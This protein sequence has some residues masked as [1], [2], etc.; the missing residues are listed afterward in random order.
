MCVLVYVCVYVCACLYVYRL[1]WFFPYLINGSGNCSLLKYWSACHPATNA[2]FVPWRSGGRRGARVEQAIRRHDAGHTCHGRHLYVI[3]RNS[4]L[5]GSFPCHLLHY[6]MRKQREMHMLKGSNYV[7]KRTR[8]IFLEKSEYV[9][10]MRRGACCPKISLEVWHSALLL[11][12][13]KIF[14]CACKPSDTSMF[15]F[16]YEPPSIGTKRCFAQR[17]RR[18]WQFTHKSN[19]LQAARVSGHLAPWV[20]GQNARDDL[21]L[22]LL[23]QFSSFSFLTRD[24]NR[25]GE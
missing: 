10:V 16:F 7:V 9:L 24:H 4:V 21:T 18:H 23:R 6:A 22:G 13:L 25:L 1:F 2:A 11:A 17:Y 8:V 14:S 19:F 20:T 12:S 5:F 3:M 15:S